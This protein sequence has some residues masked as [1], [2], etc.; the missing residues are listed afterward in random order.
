MF[1]K[2]AFWLWNETFSGSFD[3]LIT[4]FQ[5]YTWSRKMH[6]KK[7]AQDFRPYHLQFFFL[8]LNVSVQHIQAYAKDKGM[9]AIDWNFIG[10]CTLG[11]K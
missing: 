2:A 1:Q 8:N 4:T 9:G 5:A 6:N 11:Y 3:S 7:N 10:N